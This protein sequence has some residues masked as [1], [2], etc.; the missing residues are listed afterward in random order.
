[1]SSTVVEVLGAVGAV[2]KFILPRG[3]KVDLGLNA[4]GHER[5]I[6]EEILFDRKVVA[7]I[8]GYK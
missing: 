7:N 3:V 8:L 2:A 4:V 5:A 1:L 6:G